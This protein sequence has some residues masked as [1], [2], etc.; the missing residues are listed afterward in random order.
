MP[1]KRVL[2]LTRQEDGSWTPSD[3]VYTPAEAEKMVMQ[4][5]ILGG[6]QSRTFPV[7]E[8]QAHHPEWEPD[9][10]EL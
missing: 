7:K 8:Y 3:H 9:P 1:R 4:A 5:R 6:I 10:D 2:I